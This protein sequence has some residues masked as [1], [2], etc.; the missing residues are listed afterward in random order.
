MAGLTGARISSQVRAASSLLDGGP[1][2]A[3]LDAAASRAASRAAV[4][5]WSRNCAG[6]AV[7]AYMSAIAWRP[8]NRPGGRQPGFLLAVALPGFAA[9]PGALV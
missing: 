5:D 3:P 2:A 1:P 4:L 6:Q 9:R 7:A 8:R